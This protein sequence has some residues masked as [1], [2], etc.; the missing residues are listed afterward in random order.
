MTIKLH[1]V[2]SGQIRGVGYDPE[3]RTLAVEFHSGRLYHYDDVSEEERVALIRAESIGKH[4]N[5]HI[6]GAKD[7][8]RIER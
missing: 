4:F 5:Q 6:R 7:Y 3:S 1:A 8:R 2:K